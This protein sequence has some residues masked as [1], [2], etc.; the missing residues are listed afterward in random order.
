MGR[1]LLTNDD[2]VDSPALV[3]FA[4]ALGD[5]HEVAV[6]VPDGERSWIGKAITRHGIIH[7]REEDRAGWTFH[8]TT[9]TPADAVQ[10]GVHHVLAGR[11]DA[12]VSGINLG[13]NHGSAFLLSS[14]TVGAAVEGWLA[15]LPAV[16]F[17][18]GTWGGD[19]ASWRGEV[20]EPTNRQRWRELGRLCTDLLDE[21]LDTGLADH[22]DVVSINVPF[23]A[24]PETPRRVT[25]LARAGYGP[26]FGPE[27]DGGWRHQ[28][29][30]VEPWAEL[31]GT[32][33]EA[34]AEHVVT[35][36]PICMPTTPA[37]PDDVRAR[38]ERS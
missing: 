20:A 7:L 5:R 37:V 32:D 3:P 31:T 15:G 4:E 10:L 27:D 2:G 8:A 28:T 30:T 11:V 26:L 14:G 24:T 36:T 35:I 16:A 12:V 23:A 13:F 29:V 19:W 33:L 6:V 21:V 9:G 22:A 34:A 1:L 25:A 38:L 17:S 18:T